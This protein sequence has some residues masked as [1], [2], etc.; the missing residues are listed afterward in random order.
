LSRSYCSE[1]VKVITSCSL[2]IKLATNK[3]I[4]KINSILI[5]Y[6]RE[7]ILKMNICYPRKISRGGNQLGGFVYAETW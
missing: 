5:K 7:I 1:D 2:A 3:L 6:S 4:D